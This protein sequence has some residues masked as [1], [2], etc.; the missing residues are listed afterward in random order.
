MAF[1]PS[2]SKRLLTFLQ[3]AMPCRLKEVHVVRQPMAF[4]IVWNLFKPFIREKLRNRLIFHGSKM[5]SLHKYIPASHLPADFGGEL[6]RIDYS[7][8]DWYPVLK[9]CT[10]HIQAWDSYGFAKKS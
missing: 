4:N 5:P 2:S 1:T 10:P 3:D 9:D 6:P 8:A 7:A